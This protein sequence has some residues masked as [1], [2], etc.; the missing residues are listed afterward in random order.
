M[1]KLKYLLL[2]FILPAM[3]LFGACGGNG[4]LGAQAQA[5]IG[6]P[7]DYVAASAAQETA[8]TALL[9]DEEAVGVKT[10]RI[11][12]ETVASGMTMNMNCTTM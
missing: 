3:F 2:A 4:Q 12:A 6:N 9:N 5:N 8:F 10:Y 7:Q 1:K 11:T